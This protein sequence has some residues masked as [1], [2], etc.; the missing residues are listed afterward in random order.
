VYVV[1]SVRGITKGQ[2]HVISIRWFLGGTDLGLT[3]VNNLSKPID[4]DSNVYFSL[5]YPTPGLGTAKVYFDR[6]SNDS[7]D[8]TSYL[9]ATINFAVD[10]PTTPTTKG[11]SPTPGTSP[12]SGSKTPT[13]SPKGSTGA[14]PVAW[15]ADGEAA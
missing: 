6:P 1:A 7:A 10:M 3:S 9:A 4:K 12:T 11:G 14:P 5:R 8:D 2:Q 13:P 15:R